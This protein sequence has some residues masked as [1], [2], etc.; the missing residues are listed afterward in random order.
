M[1]RICITLHDADL[2]V[3]LAATNDGMGLR[4]MDVCTI[5]SYEHAHYMEWT[6]RARANRIMASMPEARR[7]DVLRVF[8][9][10]RDRTS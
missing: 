9:H 7:F 2:I 10:A 6:S 5:F 3:S 8:L 4:R 1:T